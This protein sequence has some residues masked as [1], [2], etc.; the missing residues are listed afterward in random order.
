[1]NDKIKMILKGVVFTVLCLLCL[2]SV[3]TI[4]ADKEAGKDYQKMHSIFDEPENSLDAVFL[5]SSSSYAYWNPAFAWAEKGIAVYS[6]TNASQPVEISHFIIDDVRKEQPDA[7]YIINI[8]RMLETEEY[9]YTKIHRFVNNYP[10]TVNKYKA[11]D[12]MLDIT[13]IPL[14]ERW[15]YYFPIIRFHERWKDLDGFDLTFPEEPY[16]SAS[17][18]SSYV[19]TAQKQEPVTVDFSICEEMKYLA[20]SVIRQLVG[21]EDIII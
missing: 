13:N 20:V 17:R 8:T 11:L 2:L 7:L 12:Y 16:K 9:H 4:L 18:Y 14:D 6:M 19:K 1:M 21:F 10:G 5:G 15:E 3:Q